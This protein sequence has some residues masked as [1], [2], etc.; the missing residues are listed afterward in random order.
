VYSVFNINVCVSKQLIHAK[1]TYT[2]YLS[3]NEMVTACGQLVKQ[4]CI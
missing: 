1:A 2:I 3:I 4:R